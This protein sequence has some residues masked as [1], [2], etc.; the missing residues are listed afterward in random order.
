MKLYKYTA[1][2]YGL[3]AIRDKRLKVT[4]VAD[5]NDPNEWLPVMRDPDTGFDWNADPKFKGQF[6]Y[7]WSHEYGFVSL[8]KENKSLLMWGHYADKFRGTVLAFNVM[9]ESKMKEV[10]YRRAR[11]SIDDPRGN[12]PNMQTLSEFIGRK[13]EVWG[14]EKEYRVLINLKACTTRRLP[15]G[16]TIYFTPFEPVLS[17]EGVVLGSECTVT[18]DDIHQALGRNPPLGFSIV[19]LA[20]DSPTYSLV[21]SDHKKWNGINWV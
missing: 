18:V 12:S 9:D 19:Q 7:F 13:D 21:I 2:D 17:L 10:D 14:Y 8:S 15:S 4:T 5:A 1:A 16:D 11:F 3:A 20:A 6:R